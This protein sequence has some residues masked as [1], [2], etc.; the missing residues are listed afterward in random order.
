MNLSTVNIVVK[1]FYCTFG[2]DLSVVEAAFGF[3]GGAEN[4]R[5][6]AVP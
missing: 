3:A 4:L 1:S 2:E 6:D 5:S